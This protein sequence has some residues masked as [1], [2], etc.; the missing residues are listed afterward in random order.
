MSKKTAFDAGKVWLEALL[1]FENELHEHAEGA[2]KDQRRFQTGRLLRSLIKR[3]KAKATRKDE[4][5]GRLACYQFL[6]DG[7]RELGY[8]EARRMHG[9]EMEAWGLCSAGDFCYGMP[10]RFAVAPE[11]IFLDELLSRVRSI[12]WWMEAQESFSLWLVFK[13]LRSAWRGKTLDARA[14]A[15]QA[16]YL[17][18]LPQKLLERT[19]RRGREVIGA[20]LRPELGI[21]TN[22]EGRPWTAREWQN[23]LEQAA[24]LTEKRYECTELERW[25]WWCYPVFR[26]FG[27]NTREVQEAAIRRGFTE[28]S[29]IYEANFRRRL[30]SM[31]L[32]ISGQKQ[33]RR[34]RAPLA[35]FVEHVVL[36]DP[37]TMWGAVGGF[38][39]KKNDKA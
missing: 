21:G 4:S 35:E 33:T 3:I 31:G 13:D 5:C 8:S 18:Q 9:E 28:V 6:T 30:M 1:D 2:R 38:L 39:T 23:I 10:K 22:Y 29:D 37:E 15:I 32:R 34:A 26:R 25:L 14:C 16:C 17:S 7:S 12:A 20:H 24:R 19:T 36:P 11:A 27:W